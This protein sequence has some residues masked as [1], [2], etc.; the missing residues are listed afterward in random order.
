[1]LCGGWHNTVQK[2]KLCRMTNNR[3]VFKSV[4]TNTSSAVYI[5]LAQWSWLDKQRQNYHLFKIK[6]QTPWPEST[7]ELYLLY[8]NLSAKLLP[9]FAYRD[10][11]RSQRD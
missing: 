1:M 3:I 2:P 8:H 4:Y 7:G 5:I 11:S 6:K 10:V 9:T